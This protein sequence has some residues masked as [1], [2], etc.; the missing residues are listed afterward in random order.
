IGRTSLWP[1]TNKY[2]ALM[3]KPPPSVLSISRFACSV[4]G[5]RMLRS[6]AVPPCTNS[7]LFGNAPLLI[8]FSNAELSSGGGTVPG[9]SGAPGGGVGHPGITQGV[10]RNMLL[11]SHV[12]V[13]WFFTSGR[14]AITGGRCGAGTKKN[15]SVYLSLKTPK[16]ERITVL[17]SGE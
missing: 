6:T 16:P 1:A 10:G 3:V 4:Y 17:E 14:P 5:E 2:P 12:P 11:S 15:V 7:E 9:G 13:V 8:R